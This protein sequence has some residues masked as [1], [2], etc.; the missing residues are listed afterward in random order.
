[1]ITVFILAAV[2]LYREGLDRWLSGVPSLVVVGTA[3]DPEDAL[4][5]IGA[6]RPD[7]LVLDMSDPASLGLARRIRAAVGSTKVVALAVGEA[8][9][10]VIACAEAGVAG[11]LTRDGSLNE[12]I[13]TIESTVRGETRCPP[14]IIARLF[15]RLAALSPG[16]LSELLPLTSREAQIV[17]L[18]DRGLSNKEIARTLSIA[19]PTVKNHVHNVLRKL[20][21]ERREEAVISFR[22]IA[23][24][25]APDRALL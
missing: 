20:Q 25:L 4:D 24:T 15:D 19:V 5:R 23:A 3:A 16:H 18:I 2:R 1:M 10:D 17:H 7:V 13:E 12:L 14:Q 21:V 9:A 8:G 22:R 6:L 11:Y